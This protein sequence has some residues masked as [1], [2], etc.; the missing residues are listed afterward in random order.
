MIITNV[1]NLTSHDIIIDRPGLDLITIP[2]G[3]V[4]ARVSNK[5]KMMG[6]I[7]DDED[8][9]LA[10]IFKQHK[11]ETVLVGLKKQNL[12]NHT[13]GLPLPKK[14]HYF[15]VS[16]IVAYHNSDRTDLIIPNG[17]EGKPTT[18]FFTIGDINE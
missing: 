17:S 5:N 18:H 4:S 11:Y 3:K 16:R 7:E 14:N 10:A 8:R 9:K 2:A 15:I 13:F 1:T 6:Q 12:I